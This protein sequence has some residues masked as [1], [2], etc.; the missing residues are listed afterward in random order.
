VLGHEEEAVF[1]GSMKGFKN[2]ITTLQTALADHCRNLANFRKQFTT[3]KAIVKEREDA[4]KVQHQLLQERETSLQTREDDYEERKNALDS[5]KKLLEEKSSSLIAKEDALAEREKVL[6]QKE[7]FQTCAG[8]TI[9]SLQRL[10]ADLNYR[11][12]VNTRRRTGSKT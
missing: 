9:G 5:E 11:D 10:E 12:E 3:D 8:N 2:S 1:T 7:N 6:L 4:V